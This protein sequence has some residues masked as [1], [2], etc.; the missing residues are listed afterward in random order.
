MILHV[1]PVLDL[2]DEDLH[3][4]VG[5]YAPATEGLGLEGVTIQGRVPGEERRAARDRRVPL[6]SRRAARSSSAAAAPEDAPIA[7]LSEYEQKVLRLAQRGLVY[8]YEL[9]RMLAPARDGAPGSS[10]RAS[11]SS[12]TS[13]RPGRLVP[14]ERPFGENKA[15]VIVGVDPQLHRAAT[16]RA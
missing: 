3:A 14:V 8:P 4:F 5:R 9:V 12:T 16:P 13:T 15:N 6:R 7:P 1:W 11:S 2:S 10:R